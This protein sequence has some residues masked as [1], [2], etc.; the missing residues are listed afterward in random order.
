MESEAS[1]MS[2]I[3]R[4]CKTDT[5]C[6]K[7]ENVVKAPA[8][9]NKPREGRIAKLR[10]C[11]QRMRAHEHEPVWGIQ[12]PIAAQRTRRDVA[13]EDLAMRHLYVAWSHS[14]PAEHL[15][16]ARDPGRS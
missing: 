5:I 9:I 10:G 16:R 2:F 15:R 1:E 6:G 12:T 8:I 14:H 11:A 13:R 3:E 7:L 4:F